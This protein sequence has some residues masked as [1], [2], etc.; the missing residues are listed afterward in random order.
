MVVNG[1]GVLYDSDANHKTKQVKFE[2]TP[3]HSAFHLK[4]V[5]REEESKSPNEEAHTVAVSLLVTY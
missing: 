1:P 2:F 5:M 3:I 4:S